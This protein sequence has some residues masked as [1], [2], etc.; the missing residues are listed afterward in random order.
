MS[1]IL[2]RHEVTLQPE[3]ARVII[4]P[5]IPTDVHRITT[6]IGRALALTEEEVVSHLGTVRKEFDA[7]HF[8]IENLFS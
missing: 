1:I 2:R 5:F 8:D 4:R 3:S 6:V 7:R